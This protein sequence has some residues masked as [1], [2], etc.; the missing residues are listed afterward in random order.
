MSKDAKVV[1]FSLVQVTEVTSSNV[2]EKDGFE[3]FQRALR[4]GIA[5]DRHTSISS[6][7]DK[8]HQDTCHHYDV[9]HVSKW[10]VKKVARESL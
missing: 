6:T 4:G 9:W 3:R 10:V 2:M 7:M 8:T 5:T 1:T